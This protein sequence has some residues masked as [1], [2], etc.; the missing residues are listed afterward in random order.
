MMPNIT[1]SHPTL[2]LDNSSKK[3]EIQT[4]IFLFSK[5]TLDEGFNDTTN[6]F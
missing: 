2:N 3:K 4:K 5:L 1:C 6:I